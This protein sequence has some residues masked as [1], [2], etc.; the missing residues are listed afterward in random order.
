M[1]IWHL[2]AMSYGISSFQIL[3]SWG[4]ATTKNDDGK[5]QQKMMN[6][7]YAKKQRLWSLIAKIQ[8]GLWRLDLKKCL[9]DWGDESIVHGLDG[10][11]LL[12]ST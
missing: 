5:K 4:N 2:V 12:T 1:F 6:K 3:Y 8:L 11:P 10:P 7:N 9:V